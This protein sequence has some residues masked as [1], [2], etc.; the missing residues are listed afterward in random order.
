MT[1]IVE[2]GN[3][4]VCTADICRV[5]PYKSCSEELLVGSKHFVEPSDDTPD[6]LSGIE[7]DE[8]ASAANTSSTDAL[9]G[10]SIDA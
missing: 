6:G 10:R 4:A 3:V 9:L 8:Q 5:V 2:D 1:S 7:T